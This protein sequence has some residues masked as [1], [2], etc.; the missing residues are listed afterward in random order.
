M[1]TLRR[2]LAAAGGGTSV[3]LPTTA[4]PVAASPSGGWTWFTDPRAV[5]FGGRTY[6]G[7]VNGSGDVAVR[8]WDHA[9]RTVS[10]ETVLHAALEVDDHDNPSLLVRDSDHRLLAFYSKHDDTTMRLRAST[11]S[12]DTDPDLSDGF[13][14]ELSLDASLGGSDYTYPCPIQLLGEASDPVHLFYRDIAGGSPARYDLTMAT[15]TNG[16][17]TWGAGTRITN[18]NRAYWKI[19]QTSDTRID[20]AVTSTHP[21]YGNGSIYHAYYEGGAWYKSD[22]TSAGA[23]PLDTSD[24]TL[25]YDGTSTPAWVWDIAVD[26]SGNPHILYATFPTTTDH[27]YNA[28]RW[29]GS[30]WS[31]A[32]VAAAGTY[33]PTAAVGGGSI[34]VYYSGGAVFDHAD[35]DTVWASVQTG[36]GRWDVYRY[37]TADAGASWSGVARTVAGKNVRPAPVYGAAAALGVLWM[38]GTYASYVSY[39]VGTDGVGA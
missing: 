29:S 32:E 27:R 20:I 12:L 15:S 22:G 31:S 19:V 37:R 13:D 23:L 25:V 16:G 38:S 1:T 35:P 8:S 14:A 18:I 2:L 24:M 7:Y 30:A 9:T 3:L 17:G 28:A 10:S 11:T 21:A 4:F 36:S 5:Y 39:T 34:E 6:F 33:I 26:G